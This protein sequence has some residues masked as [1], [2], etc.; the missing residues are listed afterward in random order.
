[1]RNG[2][3]PAPEGLNL[4]ASALVLLQAAAFKARIGPFALKGLA[5]SQSAVLLYRAA[6]RLAALSSARR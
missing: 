4:S 5:T 1:M 3:R 2:E 6:A